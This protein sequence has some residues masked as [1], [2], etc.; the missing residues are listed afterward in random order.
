MRLLLNELDDAEGARPGD[1]LD[2]VTLSRM[3]AYPRW[4]G[5]RSWVRANFVSTLDGAAAGAD[6]KTGS[7]NTGADHEVFTLLRALADVILVGAGTAR[8][9]G[10]RR[11]VVPDKWVRLGLR[12][13][14]SDQPVLAVVSRSAVLPATLCE[15][16]GQAGDVLLM[17][18]EAAGTVAIREAEKILGE[19]H[20]VVQ[21]DR[22]VNLGA[23]LDDLVRRGLFRILCEGGPHLLHDVVNSGRLDELCL[24]ITPEVVAGP[25]ARILVG[26]SITEQLVPRLLVESQ[27]TL[28]GRWIR[29][30]AAS[31]VGQGNQ[32]RA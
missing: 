2:D 29:P 14:R 9:E 26:P 13:D 5:D 7:I 19:D 27:G 18:C 8:I 30:D 16:Q 17:T 6:G 28:M 22:T 32:Q 25:Q 15:A 20:V 1:L 24:T 12:Q 31:D 4:E 21:G 3:Y 11:P 10:Y 23:V